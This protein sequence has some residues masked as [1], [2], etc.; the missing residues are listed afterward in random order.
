MSDELEMDPDFPNQYRRRK[1]R[2]GVYFFGLLVLAVIA[3]SIPALLKPRSG[4]SPIGPAPVIA[5]KGWVNGTGPSKSEMAGKI[6][7]V[8]VWATW[9][10]PCRKEAPVLAEVHEKYA[11]RGVV[12]V[13]LTSDDEDVMDK[14]QL[15]LS[16]AGISWPNG[17]GAEQTIR[18]LNV[19]YLPSLFVIGDDG[20]ILWQGGDAHVLPA[21][22]EKAMQRAKS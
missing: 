2:A 11:P 4:F 9:C 17:W 13:G 18:D 5:A 21:V 10:G 15:F 16:T 3:A 8:S 7:V 22:I 14:I 20:L 1:S 6:V 12:F 19:E